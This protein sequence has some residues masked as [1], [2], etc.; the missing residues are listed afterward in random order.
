MNNTVILQVEDEANEVFLLQRAFQAAG[1]T[2][3]VQVATDGQMAIDY[4]AGTGRFANR[5]SYPLPGLILLDLKLPR[6]SG[7]E[8]LEWVRSRPGLDR[9]VVIVFTSAQY[10]GD[11]GLAYELGANSFI[12][13][14]VDFSKY[15]EIAVLLKGWWLKHNQF[16]PNAKMNWFP[17]GHLAYVPRPRATLG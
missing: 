5:L 2:N 14:P 17:E 3:P 12:F 1:I 4:L 10:A 6:R 11:V 8:V 13:K 16:P 9:T 15:V 7:R